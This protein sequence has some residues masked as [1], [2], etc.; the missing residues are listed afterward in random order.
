MRMGKNSARG[1][2]AARAAVRQNQPVHRRALTKPDG[3]YLILYGRDPI[4]ADI[5]ATSPSRDRVPGEPAPALAPAARRVGRLR[6]P[7][8]GPDL[9][10]AAGVQPAGADDATRPTR[11]SC[12]PA[13]YDVAVFEN[14]FPS[15]TGG[16]HDPPALVGPDP[17]GARRLRGGRLH[18]GSDDQPRAR[19]R[20]GTSSC[21]SRSGPTATASS[22]A[23]DDVQYVMPFE[24]RGVEVGVTLHHPHGQIYAYPFV[25]PIPARELEQQRAHLERARRAGCSR[26]MIARR[27]GRRAARCSTG[28]ARGRL[29]AGLRPLHLRGLGRAAPRRPA[30]WPSSTPTSGATSRGRSRR[31]C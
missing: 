4:P 25:P 6:Q 15:L 28:R 20:S 2:S 27:A 18:P 12:R 19:C 1:R 24:N 23:R 29:R 3:R 11:P 17:A 8:A 16:A 26:T 22:G 14:R 31:C 13:R 30:R 5:E 10:A 9:P 21:C 7:P